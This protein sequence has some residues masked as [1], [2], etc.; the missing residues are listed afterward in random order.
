MVL[1]IPEQYL[2]FVFSVVFENKMKMVLVIRDQSLCFEN[3][4]RILL[5]IPEQ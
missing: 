2:C 1:G 4:E 3:K 5:V